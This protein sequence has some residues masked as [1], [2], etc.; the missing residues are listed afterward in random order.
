MKVEDHNTVPTGLQRLERREKKNLLAY[1]I[2]C[3]IY[4]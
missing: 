3:N 2:F 1:Y 4:L